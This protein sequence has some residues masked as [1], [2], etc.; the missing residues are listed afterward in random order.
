VQASAEAGP[1]VSLL[2]SAHE[3]QLPLGLVQRCDL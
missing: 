3:W 1:E 2:P